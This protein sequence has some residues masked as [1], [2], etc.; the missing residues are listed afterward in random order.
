M[1]SRLFK[2]TPAF[3]LSIQVESIQLVEFKGNKNHH[4]VSTCQIEMLMQAEHHLFDG[5]NLKHALRTIVE[6][7]GIAP[8]HHV[9]LHVPHYLVKE[10]HIIVPL[11]LKPDEIQQEIKLRIEAMYPALQDTLHFTYTREKDM[12]KRQEHIHFVFAKKSYIEDLMHAVQQAGFIINSIDIE[13]HALLRTWRY[14]SCMSNALKDLHGLLSITQ[15][16]VLLLLCKD[17]QCVYSEEA[18]WNQDIKQLN[19]FL[20]FIATT[21]LLTKLQLLLSGQAKC[22]QTLLDHLA[23]LTAAEFH[24]VPLFAKNMHAHFTPVQQCE[25]FIAFGL[26]MRTY[27]YAGI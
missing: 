9:V 27:A 1:L 25:L 11:N 3:G 16:R 19:Q 21:R 24:I 26:G 14:L 22:I 10:D 12:R 18:E 13:Q 2:K 4:T 5:D 15:K 6:R 7:A 23:E 20:M 8:S 17:N